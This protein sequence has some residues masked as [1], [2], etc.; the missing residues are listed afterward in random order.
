MC[1]IICRIIIC[2]D[3][4]YDTEVLDRRLKTYT[5]S[6]DQILKRVL[7]SVNPL[8]MSSTR[9]CSHTVILRNSAIINIYEGAKNK[10]H[11]IYDLVLC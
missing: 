9:T 7:S 3:I 1:H 5:I 10:Y 11:L 8:E 4:L 6:F 2:Y